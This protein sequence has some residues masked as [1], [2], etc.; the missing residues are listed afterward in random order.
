MDM[1]IEEKLQ[2]SLFGDEYI[3]YVK[4]TKKLLPFIY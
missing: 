1:N 4:R 2:I 3:S